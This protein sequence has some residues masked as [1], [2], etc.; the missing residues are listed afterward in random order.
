ML[1]THL[2]LARQV[3]SREYGFAGGGDQHDYARAQQAQVYLPILAVCKHV[4]QAAVM[5]KVSR[6]HV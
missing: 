4:L 3:N 5:G 6:Y 2:A 1:A